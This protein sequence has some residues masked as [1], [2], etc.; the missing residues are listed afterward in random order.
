VYKITNQDFRL[1]TDGSVRYGMPDGSLIQAAG[2]RTLGERIEH[3]SE[4]KNSHEHYWRSDIKGRAKV[5]IFQNYEIH[6]FNSRCRARR[7]CFRCWGLRTNFTCLWY[8]LL[9]GDLRSSCF[10]RI[11]ARRIQLARL[12][13]TTSCFSTQVLPDSC[14]HPWVRCQ[15]LHLHPLCE[16]QRCSGHW[17][18]VFRGRQ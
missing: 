13:A 14:S 2:R 1:N 12:E 3:G 4:S 9:R 6:S 18:S 8:L 11:V 7:L 5:S 10:R 16:R 17:T 15:H